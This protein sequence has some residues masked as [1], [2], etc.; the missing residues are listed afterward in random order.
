LLNAIA[1]T[2]VTPRTATPIS[3]ITSIRWSSS[4]KR[5]RSGCGCSSSP[6]SCSSAACS[7]LPA[8]SGLVWRGRGQPRTDVLLGGINT[9][10]LTAKSHDGARVASRP[11]SSATVAGYS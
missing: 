5:Q 8:L 2:A 11:G 9:A 1:A 10:L 6:R 4:T 3:S 7:G